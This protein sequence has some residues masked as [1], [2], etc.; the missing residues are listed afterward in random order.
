MLKLLEWL[1]AKPRGVTVAVVAVYTALIGVAGYLAGHE[2]HWSFFYL[3]AVFVTGWRLGREAGLAASLLCAVAGETDTLGAG[4]LHERPWFPWW[5]AAMALAVYAAMALMAGAMRRSHDLIAERVRQG[6]DALARETTSRQRLERELPA[7]CDRE[8]RRLGRD[9]HDALGQHLTA[10]ALAAQVLHEKLAARPAPEAN[11]ART[12]ATL[13]E[14]GIGMARD[15]ARDLTAVD[16]ATRG[17]DAELRR[18]AE[19]TARL[20]GMDCRASCHGGVPSLDASTSTHLYRIAQEAVTNAV[21]HSRGRRIDVRL[22][23]RDGY[24]LLEVAD[25]GVGL[26]TDGERSGGVG[27]RFMRCRAEMIGGECRVT[28]SAR[29]GTTVSCALGRRQDSRQVQRG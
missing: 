9:L 6:A 22:D 8:R 21:K 13:V 18:L 19:R 14:E 15:M 17:L 1:D 10:T 11:E 20:S 28:R 3:P 23:H 12:I 4:S 24:V 16:V 29:G 7:I 5:N 25:D 27:I 26:P 2:V